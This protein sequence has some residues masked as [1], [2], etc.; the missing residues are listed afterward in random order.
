MVQSAFDCSQQVPP[1]AHAVDACTPP[2]GETVKG[3]SV[4]MAAS[5]TPLM[6]RAGF[7]MTMTPFRLTVEDALADQAGLYDSI[8]LCEGACQQSRLEVTGMG[9][10][11][12]G[13]G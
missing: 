10:R 3:A 5:E 8:V 12:L 9:H 1:W 11:G 7:G 13:T 2:L 6:I 4:R